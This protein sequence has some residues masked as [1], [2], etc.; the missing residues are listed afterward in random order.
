MILAMVIAAPR[1]AYASPKESADDI[2]YAVRV[3]FE[4]R[5]CVYY[6]LANVGFDASQF[7][8]DLQLT[9]DTSKP[10]SI[11]HQ[12][13]L[14]PECLETAI[15]MAREAG[16]KD[17]RTEIYDPPVMNFYSINN[18]KNISAK[19]FPKRSEMSRLLA[20]AWDRFPKN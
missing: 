16:F 9:R 13:K 14:P 15:K 20:A 6:S 17:V 1:L 19:N 12:T 11:S 5:R 4:H 10:I 3:A 2:I 8:H 7:R 18:L